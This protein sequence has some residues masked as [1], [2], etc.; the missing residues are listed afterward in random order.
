MT[1]AASADYPRTFKDFIERFD[2][3]AACLA[4]VE[5]IRWPNGFVCP[6]CG[7]IDEPWRM[8]GGTLR[9]KAC[10]KRRAGER[11]AR[12]DR[13]HRRL[14]GLQRHRQ[15]RLPAHDHEHERPRDSRRA[16]CDAA[17]S[18]RRV[19]AQAL[20]ARHPPGRH[21]AR[22]VGLLPGRV[23]VSLQ[24][25]QLALSRAAFLPADRARCRD[26]TAPVSE[27]AH[28]SDEDA[29]RPSR[30]IP[31]EI[32]V[33]RRKLQVRRAQTKLERRIIELEIAEMI[34]DKLPE[35]VRRFYR[36]LF[37]D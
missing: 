11:Q 20:A 17:R 36:R 9:C 1:P 4:Y 5:K 2:S 37:T 22:A 13:P 14:P 31:H 23:R 3:E 24:P 7:V 19:A 34:R 33:E 21:V 6:F 35:R 29:V 27:P 12:L 26:R 16:R 28:A 18:P 25:P 10:R 30:W 32:K 8:K 15:A